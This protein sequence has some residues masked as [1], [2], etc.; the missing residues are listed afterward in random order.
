MQVEGSD[1]GLGQNPLGMTMSPL[2]I[3]TP[4]PSSIASSPGGVA[5]D[6]G[7]GG[8]RRKPKEDKICGVCGDKALGYN[9][10]AISCESC[11]AFFR[12]NALKGLDYFKCPYDEKCKMDISNRRFCKRCRLK[13]CFEIGMRKEYILTEEEKARK[14]QK[15]EDN[16]VIRHLEQSGLMIKQ[17]PGIDSSPSSSLQE[18]PLS[19]SEMG[20]IEEVVNAYRASLEISVE[21]DVSRQHPSMEDLVNIAEISVRRVIDMSKKIKCFKA[22]PQAD[23]ISLLKGGSIELLILRSV[24]SFDKETH[25]FHDANDSQEDAMN[26]GQLK[27]ADGRLFDEHMKFVRSMALDLKVDETTMILLLVI[28]LFSPDRPNLFNKDVVYKEQEK[29]SLLLKKYLESRYNST[30]AQSFYP[31]L[32]MKLV[33]IR[34]LNEEHSSVLLRVNPDAIQPLMM[35]VLDLRGDRD[36]DSDKTLSPIPTT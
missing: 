28:C 17:E 6:G 34:N 33:D 8:G 21:T 1:M 11:K 22:L 24:I 19:P 27:E 3:M 2:N 16:R 25:T 12:R 30:D 29:Y 35:E 9:F 5:M 36:S 26:V 10:D 15:I 4:S 13:K 7:G 20:M 31:K 23:Q 18:T 32:L 14:R